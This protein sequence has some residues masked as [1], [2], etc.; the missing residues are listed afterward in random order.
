MCDQENIWTIVG[1]GP[2][3][4]SK[5][6]NFK[7]HND[8]T[9]FSHQAGG[10]IKQ[11]QLRTDRCCPHIELSG[12]PSNNLVN[13]INKGQISGISLVKAETVTLIAGADYLRR[14]SLNK[15]DIGQNNLPVNM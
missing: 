8:A 9:S 4:F 13:D 5:L 15:L 7:F 1:L 3:N 6:L 2:E 14:G 12:R 11:G 10:P